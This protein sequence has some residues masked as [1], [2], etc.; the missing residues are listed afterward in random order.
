M[1]QCG[2]WRGRGCLGHHVVKG[3]G[4]GAC[5]VGQHGIAARCPAG[6]RCRHPSRPAPLWRLCC[7]HPVAGTP[8]VPCSSPIGSREGQAGKHWN[9]QHQPHMMFGCLVLRVETL[10]IPLSCNV[11]LTLTP[12]PRWAVLSLPHKCPSLAKAQCC[13]GRSGFL[14]M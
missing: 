3:V 5:M 9:G 13:L 14:Y 11:P 12:L 2:R 7:P 8:S 1:W 10:F 4:A 6:G